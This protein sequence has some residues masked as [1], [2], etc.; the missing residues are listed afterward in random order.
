MPLLILGVSL[1][2][3]Q[4][5]HERTQRVHLGTGGQLHKISDT[6]RATVG[7]MET[8]K[9][10]KDGPL[11]KLEQTTYMDAILHNV[12]LSYM[13]IECIISSHIFQ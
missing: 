9:I 6:S 11:P 12:Q 4:I 7:F 1:I 2:H 10:P 5:W 3:A 8:A 13:Q